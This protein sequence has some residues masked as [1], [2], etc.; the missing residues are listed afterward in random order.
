MAC[1]SAWLVHSA[2]MRKVRSSLY[3]LRGQIGICTSGGKSFVCVIARSKFTEANLASCNFISAGNFSPCFALL[4]LCR[5]KI[6]VTESRLCG[7]AL[8]Y[9][10][11]PRSVGMN[12]GDTVFFRSPT[13]RE[14]KSRRNIKGN[15]WIG[16]GDILSSF[17]AVP[18]GD[19]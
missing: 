14:R 7:T 12:D 9:M 4:M 13:E 16:R 19:N 17:D 8:S 2:G 5:M 11:E 6:R 3:A 10:L 15:R 1:S 18:C